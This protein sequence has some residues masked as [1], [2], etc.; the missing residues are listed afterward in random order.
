MNLPKYSNMTFIIAQ[1]LSPTH[2][3]MLVELIARETPL[4]VCEVEDGVAP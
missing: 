1:H 2:K 3:S 4:K